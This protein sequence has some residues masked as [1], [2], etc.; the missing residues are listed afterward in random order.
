MSAEDLR[1]A[2]RHLLSGQFVTGP[3][4]TLVRRHRRPLA[5][6]FREE[7]GWQVIAD[8]H[9][10]VRA[11]CTPGAG[12]VARGLRTRSGRPFDPQRYSL[13]FLVLADL[14]AAGARTTLTVLFDA[15]HSRASGIDDVDFDRNKA[16]HR[17]AFVHAVQAVADL[18]VL[19]LADGNEEAFAST[20]EGDALYRVERSHLARVLA[21]SKPPSLA[22]SPAVAVDEPHTDTEQGQRR[23]R[24]HQ[25]ARALVCE[26]VLYRSDVHPDEVEHLVSQE[27][28]LRRLLDERFGLTLETRAEGWVAVDCAG[29]LTDQKFPAIHVARAAALA[30]V[31]ASRD[32]REPDGTAPWD[33]AELEDFVA[34]L[35]RQFGASWP[36][37]SG[38][39]DGVAKVTDDAVAVLVAMRLARPAGVDT[40][41]DLPPAPGRDNEP[42]DPEATSA[43][44]PGVLRLLPAAGRFAFSDPDADDVATTVPLDFTEP[45]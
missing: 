26:P 34:G 9:G 16:A 42:D 25:I 29:T 40:N 45:A 20:G 33:R 23:R 35:G 18:G 22:S 44:R 15:V 6:L 27:H 17:R 32:R 7:F 2:A 5:E 8:D 1:D 19:E 36:I 4:A 10:P 21:T 38:D 31:D 43:D 30:I 28:R 14:E 39:T 12:H 11:L 3:A 13:V 24:R 41:P 37:A